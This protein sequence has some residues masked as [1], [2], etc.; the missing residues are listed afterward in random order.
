L[1]L[2][3]PRVDRARRGRRGWFAR[4]LARSSR[5][6]GLRLAGIFVAIASDIKAP[7]SFRLAVPLVVRQPRADGADDFG[8]LLFGHRMASATCDHDVAARAMRFAA[9]LYAMTIGRAAEEMRP[10]VWVGVVVEASSRLSPAWMSRRGRFTKYLCRGPSFDIAFLRRSALGGRPDRRGG[11]Q[12]VAVLGNSL[13]ARVG[14]RASARGANFDLPSP[15]D[16]VHIMLAIVAFAGA[17]V[18]FFGWLMVSNPSRSAMSGS[19]VG[20]D[21]TSLGRGGV[22]CPERS[23]ADGGTNLGSGPEDQCASL[24]K[25]GRICAERP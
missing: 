3:S 11:V 22:Y 15:R 20:S 1:L 12:E 16:V 2:S 19:R 25:G 4:T 5:M 21:C 9:K 13:G 14:A 10:R 8:R 18:L 7:D 6:S 23:M 17:A 24:G